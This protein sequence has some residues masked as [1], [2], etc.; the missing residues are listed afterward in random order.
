MKGAYLGPAF[1]NAEIEGYLKAQDA[2]Y[3]RLSDADL[4]KPYSD[5]LPDEPGTDDGRPAADVVYGNSAS[6][7]EEHLGWIKSLVGRTG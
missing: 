5:Y 4:R 3:V 1:S 7:F 6:H 2:P